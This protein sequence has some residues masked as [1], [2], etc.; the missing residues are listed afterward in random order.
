MNCPLGNTMKTLLLVCIIFLSLQGCSTNQRLNRLEARVDR[1]AAITA[2]TYKLVQESNER[3]EGAVAAAEGAV[4]DVQ[5]LM[6][7]INYL[8]I[9][10]E[11]ANE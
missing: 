7:K 9:L 1:D 6:R 3:S 4:Y 11:A 2:E 8:E 5:Q 10:I